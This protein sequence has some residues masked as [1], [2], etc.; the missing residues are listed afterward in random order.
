L[1]KPGVIVVTP[2]TGSLADVN[3]AMEAGYER[4]MK[5]NVEYLRETGPDAQNGVP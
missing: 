2:T 1:K 3:A 4:A 5:V